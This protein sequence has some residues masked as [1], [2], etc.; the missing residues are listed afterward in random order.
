MKISEEAKKYVPKI[1]EEKRPDLSIILITA[2]EK[3]DP[4]VRKTIGF[5][6]AASFK[7][8]LQ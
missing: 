8:H 4:N 7:S 2:D 1:V 6:S 3:S 5:G